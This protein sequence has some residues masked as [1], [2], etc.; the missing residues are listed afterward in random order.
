[1]S[2]YE[3]K[4]KELVLSVNS[5]GAELTRITDLK[6]DT[7]Y[8][9]N[10]DPAYW[11]RHSP[12]LFPIVG[13][14]KN[15]RYHYNRKE[16]SLPQHGFARD[17]EFGLM[18]S[19]DSEIWFQLNATDETKK[20]FPFDFILEIGYRLT[21]RQITVLWNVINNG[22]SDMYFSIGAHPAFLCPLKDMENQSDCY[23]SFD[24]KDTIHY[25]LINDN[26]LVVKKPFEEQAVLET[27]NGFLNINPHLF[28]EDALIIENNQAH[29]VSLADSKKNP[30][31]TVHFDAPLFGL[32]SPAGKNAPF[33]CIEPWYGRCDSNDFDGSLEDREWGNHIKAGKEFKTSYTIDII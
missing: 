19:S 31:V 30:Y 20:V 21:G 3:L 32:W 23:I 12:I 26:G 9:W 10:G 14:L 4:N 33:V 27:E 5:L 17:M 8:L 2:D 25:L 18:S 15:H 22:T 16:Y 24:N 28:D 11:K 6:T 29:T 13:S 1:M 7:D